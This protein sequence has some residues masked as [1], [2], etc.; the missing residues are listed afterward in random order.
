MG[1]LGRQGVRAG[2]EDGE[3]EGEGQGWRWMQSSVGGE[4]EWGEMGPD[5]VSISV[6]GSSTE[7]KGK[8]S[9]PRYAS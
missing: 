8:G 7:F 2:E 4:P 1:G 5:D 9:V 3:G 6:G